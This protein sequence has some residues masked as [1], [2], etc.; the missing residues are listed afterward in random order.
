M[1][2]LNPAAVRTFKTLE[3]HEAPVLGLA[4]S[5]DGRLLASA[6]ADRT[7]R[8]WDTGAWEPVRTLSGHDGPVNKLAFT[9]DGRTLL[10]ASDDKTARV[11]NVPSGEL[12]RK[13]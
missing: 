5:P 12:V 7:I 13:W 1:R 9:P 10:S 3:G 11:W 6:S 2:P 4:F 8:L